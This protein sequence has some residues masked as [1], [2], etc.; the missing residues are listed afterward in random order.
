MAIRRALAASAMA[1][2]LVGGMAAPAVAAESHLPGGVLGLFVS[3]LH[4]TGYIQVSFTRTHPGNVTDGVNVGWYND[5][6]QKTNTGPGF[7]KAAV[8]YTVTH[9]WPTWIG[10]GC[11][12]PVLDVDTNGD[13][14][15]DYQINKFNTQG[16]RAECR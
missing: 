14:I 13:N 12:Y 5:R 11:T 16:I 2:A 15:G 3:P 1:A 10:P 8:G 4:T 9:T 7:V 6:T